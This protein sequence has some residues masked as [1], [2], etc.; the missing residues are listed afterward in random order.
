MFEY[1]IAL[2][3]GP[4]VCAWAQSNEA[5]RQ[6]EPDL[7]LCEG[8][9]VEAT[10]GA[11]IPNASISVCRVG[12]VGNPNICSTY[13]A[14]ETGRFSLPVLYQPMSDYFVRASKEG[15]VEPGMN[16]ELGSLSQDGKRILKPVILQ[17][18]A[19]ATVSGDVFDAHGRP[20]AN[21][22]IELHSTSGLS[23]SATVSTDDRGHFRVQV[24]PSSYSICAKPEY[25]VSRQWKIPKS[26]IGVVPV[27]TCFSS[28]AASGSASILELKPAES[29]GPLRISL[30][31]EKAYS[32]RGRIRT[33]VKKTWNWGE[34]VWAIP[35]SPKAPDSSDGIPGYVE[36]SGAFR[37]YGL[38]AGTYTIL[39]RAGSAPQSDTGP[40]PPE[41][42]TWRQVR[43]GP[44]AS[45]IDLTIRPHVTVTGRVILDGYDEEPP[46]IFLD[47]GLPSTF[48][49]PATGYEAGSDGRF[50]I[51]QVSAGNYKLSVSSNQ[52]GVYIAGLRQNGRET[53]GASVR[54][55]NGRTTDLEVRLRKSTAAI[56]ISVLL[57]PNDP[58]CGFALAI[59][60][61]AWDRPD[62]WI[63]RFLPSGRME[64]GTINSL[65]PGTYSILVTQ[66]LSG[67][68]MEAWKDEVKLHRG[69]A[70]RVAVKDGAIETVA[71]RPVMLKTGFP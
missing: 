58:C 18:L 57:G 33:L 14:D 25:Q 21:A 8:T 39:A 45:N 13:T 29:V 10:T 36:R 2:M 47:A 53:S 9:V 27:L 4:L 55:E 71:I 5:L 64:K 35:D 46:K 12:K 49:S 31:E 70:V 56:Q 7:R 6:P 23:R 30:R 51:S 11:S 24:F 19:M 42:D 62:D 54:V 32:I 1:A 61:D 69:D 63:A 28:A 60:E 34:D 3:A 44:G 16:R 43:T 48:S 66:N 15:Y 65:V 50:R 68:S 26:V 52:K 59:P 17:L 38:R 37:I 40:M 67:C 20:A 41:F 22:S